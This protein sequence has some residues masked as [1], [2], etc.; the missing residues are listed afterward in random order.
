MAAEVADEAATKPKKRALGKTVLLGINL[1]LF[2]AGAGFFLLTKF[3]VIN[4]PLANAVKDHK[5]QGEQAEPHKPADTAADKPAAAESEPHGHG[6]TVP[7]QPFA[8]NLGGDD[9]RRFLRLVL[10]LDVKDEKAKAEIDKRLP[11]LRNLLIFLLSSKSFADISSVQGKYQLQ[12]EIHK[13]LNETL[14]TPLVRKT[15]FTE[16]IVQ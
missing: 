12:A 10:T 11:H 4:G 7:L 8:V 3:G 13:A 5:A 14:G 9:G 1:L 2:L 16:F 15:Y 6:V